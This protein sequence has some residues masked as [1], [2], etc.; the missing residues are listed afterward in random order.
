MSNILNNPTY[1]SEDNTVLYI[2]IDWDATAKIWSNGTPVNMTYETSAKWYTSECWVFNWSSSYIDLTTNN[3]CP[4]WSTRHFS[5]WVNP[6]DLSWW[7]TFSSTNP[8]HI[9]IW[10]DWTNIW[11]FIRFLWQKIGVWLNQSWTFYQAITWAILSTSVWQKIDV[12]IEPSAK[13]KIYLNN[14]LQTNVTDDT[15][16]STWYNSTANNEIGRQ[17]TNRYYN[18]KLWEV[19][20]CNTALSEQEIQ[21]LYLQGLR[22]YGPTANLPTFTTSL[23]PTAFYPL[24]WDALDYAWSND[25]TWSGS[26]AYS[27]VWWWKSAT[28][29]WST[30]YIDISATLYDNSNSFSISAWVK[31]DTISDITKIRWYQKWNSSYNGVIMSTWE[32]TDAWKPWFWVY[33]WSWK[34]AKFPTASVNWEWYHIVWVY[35]STSNTADIYVNWVAWTQATW[36]WTV[37]NWTNYHSI[38]RYFT[39]EFNWNILLVQIYNTILSQADITKLYN[40]WAKWILWNKYSLPLLQT[41]LELH[42]TWVNNWTTTLYDQSGNAVNWTVSSTPTYYKYWLNTIIS[43][44]SQSISWASTTFNTATCWEKVSWTWELQINPAYITT[45]W[46]SS[47]TREITDIRLYSRTLSSEEQDIL[48]Y[49]TFIR[50]V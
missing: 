7:D 16:P 8:R 49:W 43:L 37:T 27:P 47:W 10:D 19:R 6:A 29:N 35:N 11:Y 40:E 14:I 12:V 44:S 23:S 25:W 45:T 26:E 4:S 41:D 50:T 42:L 17:S 32:T 39:Q 13:V 21:N 3:L 36:I 15:M 33:D 24:N 5:F 1:F 28:F 48:L 2:P 46:V 38:W 22:L 9:I 34:Y 30:D 31:Y 18:W 20:I